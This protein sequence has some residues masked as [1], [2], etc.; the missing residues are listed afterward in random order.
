MTKQEKIQEAYGEH[1]ETVKDYIDENGWM[2][3]YFAVRANIGV[4]GSKTYQFRGIE[5]GN[6][7]YCRIL[8]LS[9]LETNNGWIKI[10]SE[11]DLPK[12]KGAYWCMDKFMETNPATE[13]F[14]PKATVSLNERWVYRFTH[15]Q[16]IQKPQPPIY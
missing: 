4:I 5:K 9:E 13:F 1:W 12:E 6:Y 10:E 8:K 15:Y 11:D 3:L 2:T 16:P 7:K 14:D